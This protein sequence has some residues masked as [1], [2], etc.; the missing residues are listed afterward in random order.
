VIIELANAKTDTLGGTFVMT[1]DGTETA[2]KGG[3]EGIEERGGTEAREATEE[4][5]E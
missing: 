1:E 5:G 3:I 4:T 2:E